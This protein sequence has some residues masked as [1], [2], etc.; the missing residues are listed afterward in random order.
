MRRSAGGIFWGLVL[1]GA[2]ALLLA[3]NLGYDIRFWGY[4]ARYWPALL[5]VWGV[6]KFVDYYRFK[7]TGDRRPLFSGSEVVLLV[8]VIFAGAAVTTA[9]NISSN[10]GTIFEI[11]DV[12]LW[13]ITG[14]NFTFDE[15]EEAA[16]PG[17]SMIEIANLFG[18]VEVRASD[19]DRVL[20]DV[21]KTIRASDRDE[22]ERLSKDFTFSISNDGDKYRIASNRVR[23]RQRYKSSLTLQ[24]PKRSA[25]HITNR[26]GKIEVGDLAGNQDI[27]NRFG[28][29]EVRKITGD[30]KVSNAFG[31]IDID[32][33]QGDVTVSG[34][35][36]S[37]HIQ[38]VEGD[39]KADSSFQNVEIRE[40][41]G[42]VEVKGR[43]GD[44]FVSFA[45]PVQKEVRLTT[46]FGNV[47][48]ELP[49]DSSFNLD[50]ETRFGRI[51]SDFKGL[52]DKRNDFARD[53]ATAHIGEGGPQITV[54]TFNGNIH[55]VRRS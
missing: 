5:I 45:R 16:V 14:N 41:T 6:L 46:N 33:V 52:Q 25:L 4:V 18:D 35:N 27:S 9:A 1:I 13:D 24:V 49:A 15:H 48:V 17:G 10:V 42:A 34:R 32:A 54:S 43:N 7:N 37:I 23:S 3:R 20:L 29:I 51:D 28:A 50:A 30:V 53:S 26:N 55:I 47:T 11:G 39:V 44:L 31:G 19:T 2:G 38:H 22:A 40:A 36:N 12:D 8:F 21:K